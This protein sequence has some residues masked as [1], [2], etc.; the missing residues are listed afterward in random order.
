MIHLVTGVIVLLQ[1][2]VIRIEFDCNNGG[3]YDINEAQN[4]SQTKRMGV[5]GPWCL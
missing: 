1:M 5:G 4:V 3:N 2:M